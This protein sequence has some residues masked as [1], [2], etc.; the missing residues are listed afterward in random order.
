M[1]TLFPGTDCQ[2][3]AGPPSVSSALNGAFYVY[4]SLLEERKKASVH[5]IQRSVGVSFPYHARDVGLA[6]SLKVKS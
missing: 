5:N 3:M 6:R 2:E 1:G 4:R